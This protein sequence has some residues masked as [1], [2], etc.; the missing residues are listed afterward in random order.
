MCVDTTKGLPSEDTYSGMIMGDK[1]SNRGAI[2]K[3]LEV[4]GLDVMDMLRR[5]RHD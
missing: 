1:I 4:R 3:E 5:L 2:N